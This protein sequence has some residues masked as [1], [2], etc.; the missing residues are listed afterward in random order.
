MTKPPTSGSPASYDYTPP[1]GGGA[2]ASAVSAAPP[3]RR[4][5]DRGNV[6]LGHKPLKKKFVRRQATAGAE[7]IRCASC[8]S[9][10]ELRNA[11]M[12]EMVTCQACGAVLDLSGPEHKVLEKII[13]CK[14]EDHILPLGAKGELKGTVWECVGRITMVQGGSWFWDEYL[15]FS[16]DKGYAWLQL[17]KGHWHFFRKGRNKP[18]QDPRTLSPGE[19]F[20]HFGETFKV[21]E[22]GQARVH[23]IEGEFPYQAKKGDPSGFMDAVAPPLILSGEWTDKEVEWLSGD[24]VP[25]ERIA[26]AF[27]LDKLPEPEGIGAAQPFEVPP[28]RRQSGWIAFLFALLFIGLGMAAAFSGKKSYVFVAYP[29]QYMN[30]APAY[31]SGRFLLGGGIGRVDISPAMASNAWL[32]LDMELVK[33]SGEK[34]YDMA[35][36]LKGRSDE[37]IPFKIPEAGPYRLTLTGQ[38]GAGEASPLTITVREGLIL[39]RWFLLIGIPLFLLSGWDLATARK[40]FEAQREDDE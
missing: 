15:L 25:R 1:P 18:S 16:P 39:K 4:T 35:R 36:N 11:A 22:N 28:A 10:I 31:I 19:S 24:Y 29:E 37:R 14:R 7:T 20:H 12:S 6:P 9:P 33:D 27:Q 38:T 30:A 23:Y 3:P 8:G 32:Y 2:G 13:L 17:E 34:V 40:R 21:L 5:P 26:E